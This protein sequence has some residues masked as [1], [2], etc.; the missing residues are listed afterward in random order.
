MC[1]TRVLWGVVGRSLLGA[2]RALPLPAVFS[3][4]GMHV[5]FWELR[6]SATAWGA[7]VRPSK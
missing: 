1:G 3:R 2:S 7:Y 4:L 6:G 5:R